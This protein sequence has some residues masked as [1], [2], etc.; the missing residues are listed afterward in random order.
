MHMYYIISYQSDI[1]PQKLSIS[2]EEE[3]N[4][5][6]ACIVFAGFRLGS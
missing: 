1:C 5:N 2:A 4:S 6:F 3:G